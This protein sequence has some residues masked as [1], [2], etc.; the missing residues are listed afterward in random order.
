ML[1]FSRHRGQSSKK[2]HGNICYILRSILG[3]CTLIFIAILIHQSI[4]H[5]Q[6]S[7]HCTYNTVP[8]MRSSK[9]EYLLNNHL[10]IR[11]HPLL[12]KYSTCSLTLQNTGTPKTTDRF[13]CY[14]GIRLLRQ[15]FHHLHSIQVQSLLT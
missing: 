6:M 1:W 3:F 8:I 2:P 10:T 11:I 13:I 4:A 5:G 14:S 12:Y 7:N 15:E 9:S